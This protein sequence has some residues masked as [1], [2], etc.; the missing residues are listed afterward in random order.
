MDDAREVFKP[1]RNSLGKNEDLLNLLNVCQQ[2]RC[3]P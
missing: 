2:I 1:G 3:D